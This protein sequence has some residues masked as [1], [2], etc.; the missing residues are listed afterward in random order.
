[1]DATIQQKA[2][3]FT[4]SRRTQEYLLRILEQ[5]EFASKVLLF[6]GTN[7]DP[8]SK[9]IYHQWLNRHAG[10]DRISG[11]P[12]ADIRAALVD[13]FRDEAVIMIATEAA[14]EGINLQF[15]NLVVNYDL[16][17]NPQR[18]EQRIGRC[19]RYGQKFDVVVVN[20]LN[21]SN[22]A[23]LRVYQLLDQKFRLFNGVFGASD[24]VLG[25][26]ESGVDFE[27]RIATIY[28]KCRTPE[29]IQFE[30]DA[31][32]RDLESEIVEGQRD[33]R[34]KLLNNFDQD[35]VEKV[36]IQSLA[37]LDRFEEQLWRLTCYLL[38]P[39]ARFTEGE[40]SFT[41]ERN[42]FPGESIHSGPYRMGKKVTD[43]N[44]F[45]VGHPLA[46]RLLAQAKGLTIQPG[47][48]TFRYSESGKNIS[49]LESLKGKSGW[50]MCNHMTLSGLEIEDHLLLAGMS[51]SG[52]SVEDTQCRRLFDLPG[53]EK[54][55]EPLPTNLKSTL[56]GM[57]TR[58]IQEFLDSIATKN[59]MWFEVEME[60]IDRWA[61]DRRAS[62]KGELD[63]LDETINETK[64]AARLAPNLPEK[65]ERQRAVRH[66]ESK[67]T[68]A[69][70][71][72]D[73]ASREIERQ[74][75]ALLDEISRRLEQRIEQAPL[76]TLRWSVV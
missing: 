19:H 40:H 48:V 17:W 53:D 10:T 64:K 39:Y 47:E 2:I 14:S 5:T 4:E 58:Q 22:A 52:E 34:E 13:Y 45:R 7:N 27:K 50:L 16:P 72:F 11:S 18:I 33:A 66:L 36:R 20:F 25:A 32:Q 26:V 43:A 70:K 3:I 29:Q 46:Q 76:F 6:N 73:E 49:I 65:L 1:M 75:D 31:L 51:D 57:I 38:T 67:R 44:T 30:F 41:L 15:C 24:E 21:R 35:V 23:D 28:Q 61:E 56:E 68:E 8:K 63:E 54:R 60:K 42:P 59:G 12:S 71:T 74:K 55:A 69:W 9:E 62:L 37:Y